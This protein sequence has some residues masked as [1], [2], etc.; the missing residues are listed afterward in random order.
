[1]QYK[2]KFILFRDV[3]WDEPEQSEKLF[4]R[5]YLTS[6]R[7]NIRDG[8]FLCSP[9]RTAFQIRESQLKNPTCVIDSNKLYYISRYQSALYAALLNMQQQCS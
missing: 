7:N 6:A 1:M 4:V 8:T 9:Q 3:T 5:K 2:N